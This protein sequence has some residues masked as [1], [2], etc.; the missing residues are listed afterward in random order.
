MANLVNKVV[1][2]TGAGKGTG[3]AIAAAFAARGAKLAI[4]DLTPV[5]LDQTEAEIRS[6]GG[7]VKSY[8]VD[9]TKKMPIQGLVNSVLDDWGQIDVLVNCASVK[10]AASLLDMDDWDWQRT[11][12]V[13]LTGVF[14]LMQAVARVM[15]TRGGGILLTIAPHTHQNPNQAAYRVSKAGLVELSAQASREFSEHGIQV[16]LINPAEETDFIRQVLELC[17]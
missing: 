5:N 3:R 9:V 16:Y 2:V 7:Q 11:L 14:L 15:R 8:I 4:N 1:L 13:N 12:D 17:K 6:N 10:P